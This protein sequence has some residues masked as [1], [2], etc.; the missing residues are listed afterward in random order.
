MAF[1]DFGGRVD[2]NKTTEFFNTARILRRILETWGDLLSLKFQWK[3]ISLLIWRCPWCNGNR[4]WIS[5]RR[6]EFKSWTRLIAFHIALVP[7]KLTRK[8]ERTN[9]GIC[10]LPHQKR[11]E[12]KNS[13]FK[14]IK[15]HLK[16]DLV[17]YPVRA[18]GLVNIYNK[19]ICIKNSY[20]KL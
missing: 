16:I 9:Q 15:L 1:L 3:T 4:R 8:K 12:K 11:K 17:S 19:I 7:L 18:D 10:G 2:P 20:L 14:P 5:T 13:V 6:H